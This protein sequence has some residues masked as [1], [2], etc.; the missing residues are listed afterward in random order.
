[1]WPGK[2]A[3]NKGHCS[4]GISYSCRRSAQSMGMAYK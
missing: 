1:M 3:S 2:I 4:W